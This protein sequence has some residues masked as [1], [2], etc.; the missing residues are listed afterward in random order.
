MDMTLERRLRPWLRVVMTGLVDADLAPEHH[1]LRQMLVDA[2]LL[3]EVNDGQRRTI[4]L[5]DDLAYW[6]A[7][8]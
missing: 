5:A 7:L 2:G 1:E 4:E 8:H 6:L 3:V